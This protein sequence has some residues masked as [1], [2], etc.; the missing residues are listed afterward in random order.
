[1]RAWGVRESF[2]V[3]GGAGESSELRFIVP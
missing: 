2:T 3:D 1:M